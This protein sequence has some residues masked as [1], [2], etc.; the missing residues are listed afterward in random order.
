MKLVLGAE[1]STKL[2]GIK[3]RK[4]ILRSKLKFDNEN[5]DTIDVD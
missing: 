2:V 3:E 1:G 5:E 4:E